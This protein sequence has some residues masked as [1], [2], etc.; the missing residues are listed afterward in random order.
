MLQH[1]YDLCWIKGFTFLQLNIVYKK[2][3]NSI[4]KQNNLFFSL[5]SASIHHC[6]VY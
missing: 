1:E 4:N 3:C 2:A 6:I 5:F